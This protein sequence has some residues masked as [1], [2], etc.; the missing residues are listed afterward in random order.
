MIKLSIIVPIY[1]VEKYLKHCLESIFS[2]YN[3][4]IE[5]I[6]IN[7]GSK[8]NSLQIAM[9]FVAKY[10]NVHLINQENKGLSVAR[11]T[12]IKKAKGKYLLFVDSDD[13]IEDCIGKILLC[14][15]ADDADVYSLETNIVKEDETYL[16]TIKRN[17]TPNK[18][19]SG[20]EM[21]QK[22][23][24]PFSGVPF[25]LFKRKF[26]IDNCLYFKER[27]LYDDWQ[28]LLRVFSLM[29]GCKELNLITYN[30]RLRD[31][32]I[33]TSPKTYK[34]FHDCIETACDYY[35]FLKT[36]KLSND[37]VLMLYKG[38]CKMM[39]DSYKLSIF[40]TKNKIQRKKYLDYYFTK[41]IWWKAIF[42]A[43]DIK[44]FIAH[45]L[46]LIYNFKLK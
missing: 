45:C 25:Y 16:K 28:F 22:L 18:T 5:I 14:I 15:Q 43:R 39:I 37:V 35:N 33:S 12:G 20:L 21:F 19:Y 2:Q 46:F 38:I 27:A 34:N 7:D 3:E 1:N 36:N 4:Q 30:Y 24:F 40:Y 23:V 41:R 44:A 13:W 11:N 8:D 29:N 31:N 9:E 32:T 42:H 17:L 26:L 10:P 6:M